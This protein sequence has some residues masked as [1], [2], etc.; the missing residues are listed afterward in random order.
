MDKFSDKHGLTPPDAQ[1][2]IRNEAPKKLRDAII[3]IAYDL[4]FL[5]TKV[6]RIACRSLRERED[7]RNWSYPNVNEEVHTL[8]DSCE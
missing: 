8:V 7:P 5:P 6:R 1:I 4:A 3:A 2:K